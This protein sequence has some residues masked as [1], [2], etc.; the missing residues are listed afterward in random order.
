MKSYFNRPFWFGF[1]SATALLVAAHV[2][3]TFIADSRIPEWL[4][5]FHRNV[6]DFDDCI[7]AI[8]SGTLV[9]NEEGTYPIPAELDRLRAM[10]IWSKQD[11]VFFLFRPRWPD[12]AYQVMV[13]DLKG[14]TSNVSPLLSLFP[15]KTTYHIQYVRGGW[16]FWKHD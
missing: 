4:R 14:G 9:A 7:E 8:R 1:L 5:I 11:L 15:S 2:I 16:F 12:D 10:K 3:M 13:Y 6:R